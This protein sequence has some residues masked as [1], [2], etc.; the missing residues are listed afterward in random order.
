MPHP[1]F[2]NAGPTVTAVSP[3]NVWIGWDDNTQSHVLHWDGHQW[4]TV[5]LPFYADP[6]DIVP[7]GK[8]GYWF[9]ATAILTGSTWT[10]E[11]VPG[12][13]GGYGG[14]TRIPGTTSFLLNAGVETGSP[15]TEKP[16]VFRFD[17]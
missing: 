3:S 17:L 9:G 15:A 1:A 2:N 8:G 6:L 13:T 12:F 10:E 14:V 5:T 16:T 11:H 7:D 4:H